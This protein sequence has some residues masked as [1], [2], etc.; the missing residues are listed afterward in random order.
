MSRSVAIFDLDHALLT[1]SPGR[2]LARALHARAEPPARIVEITELLH[3]LADASPGPIGGELTV[4]ALVRAL[5]G[6]SAEALQKAGAEVAGRVPD[7]VRPH[8]HPILREH[9]DSGH[10]LVLTTHL[11]RQAAEPIREALEFDALAAT[12]TS[13]EDG[14]LTGTVDG[15][16]SW[17]RGKLLRL[18]AWAEENGA[19][20]RRSSLYA[21]SVHDA[22]LLAEVR[23][24]TVVDP[25][26]TLAALAWLKGWPTR[27]LLVP[28]GVPRIAG[29]ELQEWIRPFVRPELVPYARFEL[30]DLEHIPTEGPAIACANHR[31][32]F[33]VTA[34][35]LVLARRGRSA[36]FLGKK[37]VFDVPVVGAVSRWAGGI[38]VERG[39]GSDEPLRAAV[40]A[41]E[42]GELIT[43]MPQGTIPRG[44]AFFD[45]EL[46]GRWGAARLAATAE[47][48]VIP[49]GL[50]GTEKVWPRA[51]RLP[52][53][54]VL[55]PPTVTV[56]AGPPVPLS[57]DD[58]DT[59]TKA[60]MAA[61]SDLLPEEAHVRRDP[62]PEELALTYPPGYEGDPSEEHR[63]RP[64]TDA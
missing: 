22:P 4:R 13:E 34:I 20:L 58:P 39:T 33:D 45:P 57:G 55:D 36:R 38:R 3:A 63:R 19:S 10:R 9:R 23:N 14:T 42:A 40:G 1:A 11:P 28:P 16:V 46:E 51:H 47:V 26:P 32:Y 35:G 48:P 5:R 30:H 15:P 50:W 25:D 7:L 43:I 24:P 6:T 54:D 8:A 60:I 44:P 2:L 61:I 27:S 17:G 52:R 49:V 12:D 53:F 18:R 37:E 31:S 29:R 64:G 62:T 21:G 56:R 59:D 41:L